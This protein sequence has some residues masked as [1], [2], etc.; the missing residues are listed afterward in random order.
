MCSSRYKRECELLREIIRVR[1]DLCR[2]KAKG[3]IWLLAMEGLCFFSFSLKKKKTI[4]KC[5]KKQ[6]DVCGLSVVICHCLT[7]YAVNRK[8]PEVFSVPAWWGVVSVS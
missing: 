3:S 7:S 6:M 4:R 5:T 1:K 2:I 8:L